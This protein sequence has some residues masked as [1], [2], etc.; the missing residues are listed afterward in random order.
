MWIKALKRKN[1]DKTTWL[2]GNSGRVCSTHFI[3]GIPPIAANPVPTL[4]LGYEKEVPK[5][6]RE[7][8]HSKRKENQR[9]INKH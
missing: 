3:D 5:S 6:R 8:F 7:L 1:M 9:K 4:H 2:P